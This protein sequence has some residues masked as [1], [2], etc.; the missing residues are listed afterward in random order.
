M[1]N[2]DIITKNVY[3]L[4]KFID[5]LVEDTLEAKGCS[6]DLTMPNLTI[7]KDGEYFM[8]WEDWLKQEA[9]YGV[10]VTTKGSID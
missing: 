3:N 6:R 5:M 1:T 4:E 9:E 2:F 8:G 7:L 10:C